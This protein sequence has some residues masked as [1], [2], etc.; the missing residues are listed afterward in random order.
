MVCLSHTAVVVSN[1]DE[2][3]VKLARWDALEREADE[4]EQL[5]KRRGRGQPSKAEMFRLLD[6]SLAR[7]RHDADE[8]ER[9]LRTDLAEYVRR[10]HETNESATALRETD[11]QR[12]E[13]Q[14]K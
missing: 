9:V 7:V 5:L 12:A 10:Q 11:H 2:H 1:N 4:W 6:I 3:A 14:R 8:L 13:E